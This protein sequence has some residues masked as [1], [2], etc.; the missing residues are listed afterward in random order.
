[1]KLTNELINI[2]INDKNL[3]QTEF[4]K[5][6][7]CHQSA[8]S[9]YCKRNNI[10]LP[11]DKK[12]FTLINKNIRRIPMGK[13]GMTK[14]FDYKGRIKTHRSPRWIFYIY[15]SDYSIKNFIINIIEENEKKCTNVKSRKDRPNT[16]II[17]CSDKYDISQ[18]IK[19]S[20]SENYI[21]VKVER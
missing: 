18:Y 3:S 21:R 10:K 14:W 9:H 8:I 17:K 4:A 13:V 15:S 6:I 5:R 11:D 7:G 12:G 20:L 2:W 1:M 16:W 19:E